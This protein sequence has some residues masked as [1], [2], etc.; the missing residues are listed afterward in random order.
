[1]TPI[2]GS[3]LL[4]PIV[5]PEGATAGRLADALAPPGD[6]FW[7]GADELGRS[8]LTRLVWA[9]RVSLAVA[10][11]VTLIAGV[12]GTGVGLLAGCAPLMVGA[13]VMRAVDAVLAIPRLP[14]YMVLLTLVGPGFW[15]LIIIM[16][17]LEWTTPARLA[18]TAALG[19]F[20]ESYV[21]SARSLGSSWTR[22]VVRHV[23]P[24]VLT[25][26]IVTSAVAFRTRIVAEASLSFLG[27]GIVPPTPSWGN[28]L[29]AAQSHVWD[30]PMIAVY[31]GVAILVVTIA[32]N[33]LGDAAR[34]ALDPRASR[35]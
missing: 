31:P 6:R 1:L 10:V 8:I 13:I 14:L 30:R 25:P 22:L 35:S 20:R 34:D 32:A 7:L 16:A 18:Y 4:A 29:A 28:M 9:G 33:L 27:F 21:D 24:N 23:L 3:A 2:L 12:I 19:Q 26:I 5:V 11:I 15:S 17:L